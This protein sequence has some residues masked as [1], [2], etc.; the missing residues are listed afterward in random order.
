MG[1]D[2]PIAHIDPQ[3]LDSCVCWEP[4]PG[5]RGAIVLCWLKPLLGGSGPMT[6]K[7]LHGDHKSPKDRV[8]GPFP[9]GH[10]HGL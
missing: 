9:T 3:L 4:F 6:C 10:E 7:R 2:R 1:V 5:R 8:V